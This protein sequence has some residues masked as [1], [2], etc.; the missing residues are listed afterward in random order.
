MDILQTFYRHH[1]PSFILEHR[2]SGEDKRKE[3]DLQTII[4]YSEYECFAKD[5]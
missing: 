2:N 5:C 1:E 3:D 4:N